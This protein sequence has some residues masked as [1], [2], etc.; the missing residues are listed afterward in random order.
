MTWIAYRYS[1]E[2]LVLKVGELLCKGW[3]WDVF[4]SHRI[5]PF[6]GWFSLLIFCWYAEGAISKYFRHAVTK[7]R[8]IMQDIVKPLT[9]RLLS[10]V[11]KAWLNWPV[12]TQN[13]PVALNSN[14]VKAIP[15]WNSNQFGHGPPQF[16]KTVLLKIIYLNYLQD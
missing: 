13:A 16:V 9:L 12:Q 1:T 7:G 10:K 11:R 5:F 6:H 3:C 14:L 4:E 15:L 2:H 8:I